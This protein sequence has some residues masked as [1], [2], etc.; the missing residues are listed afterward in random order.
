MR[1]SLSN[2]VS[3][4]IPVPQYCLSVCPHGF[5]T[6]FP[7]P[8]SL[9]PLSLFP[10]LYPSFSLSV[11]KKP[12]SFSKSLMFGCVGWLRPLKPVSQEV[13]FWWNIS[14]YFY[15]IMVTI[16]NIYTIR[17]RT[18][19]MMY[20]RR[21]KQQK[22]SWTLKVLVTYFLC[23]FSARAHLGLTPLMNTLKWFC[24]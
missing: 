9:N 14:S 20:S 23:F 19:N 2:Y 11:P 21:I 1:F 6:S 4:T 3:Q 5:Y 22:H 12:T 18:G 7:F 8:P 13:Y 17:T 16:I 15:R 24:K 10:N